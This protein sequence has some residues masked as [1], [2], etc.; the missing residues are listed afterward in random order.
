MRWKVIIINSLFLYLMIIIITE[1]I[2]MS[3]IWEGEKS[4]N[5]IYNLIDKEIS[6]DC[7]IL[8]L[9]DLAILQEIKDDLGHYLGR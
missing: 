2:I 8:G 5:L 9:D 1:V 3:R 4:L 7:S 6:N